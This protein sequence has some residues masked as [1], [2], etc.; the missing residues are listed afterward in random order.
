MELTQQVVNRLKP[1]AREYTTRCSQNTGF[2]VRVR[3]NGTKT[4]VYI[5]QYKGAVAKTA[6]GT[7]P[8]IALAEALEAYQSLRCPPTTPSKAPPEL[9]ISEA[10][11]LF[12]A[13]RSNDLAYATLKQ[14]GELIDA[15]ID[16]T[17][18]CSLDNLG[19][20]RLEDALFHI[21]ERYA[22]K[23]NRMRACVS[24][25][26]KTLRAKRLIRCANPVLGMAYKREKAKTRKLSAQELVATLAALRTSGIH[27]DYITAI[28]LALLTGQR[29]SEV[30]GI[31]GREVDIQA[32]RW[33][34]PAERTKN[35]R[36]HLVPL[37]ESACKLLSP[38]TLTNVQ[39][40]LLKARDG[41]QIKP[42]AVRQALQ[43]TQVANSIVACSLH[44]LRRTMAH[45]VNSLGVDS[46]LIAQLLNHAPQGVT[47]KH[48][49][50]A[51]L[52]DGEDAKRAALTLWS[53]TLSQWAKAQSGTI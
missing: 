40:R 44:D 36:E 30:C 25:L 47:A 31:E 51:G 43:R 23:G 5:R 32:K 50:Q 53:E 24:S 15:L 17:G 3:P 18:D 13:Q 27:Q 26:F 48:Y 8:D 45:H 35:S 29:P 14:Y 41:S 20:G 10:W 33:V 9:S 1:R 6:L 22:A 49:I 46:T 38:Y 42:Y 7:F 12:H 16:I 19:D 4:F 21:D 2:A 39:G 28:H 37:S 52:F 34:I 11:R